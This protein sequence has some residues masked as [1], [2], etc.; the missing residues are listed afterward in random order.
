MKKSAAIIFLSL[1]CLIGCSKKIFDAE[2]P[3]MEPTIARGSKVEVDLLAYVET[4][5]SRYDI[6]IFTPPTND[7]HIF[8]FRVLGLPGE[9]IL[10]GDSEPN[11]NGKV[12]ST[13][14]NIMYTSSASGHKA[15]YND[16]TLGKDEYYLVGDNIG[17]AKDSRFLGPISIGQIKGKVVGIEQGAAAD[18][19]GDG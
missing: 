10:L 11:I 16:I 7:K 2:S 17:G 1:L 3:S 4:K 8:M 6:V 18:A 5:P 12:V 15:K 13:Q 14:N 9:H 19:F